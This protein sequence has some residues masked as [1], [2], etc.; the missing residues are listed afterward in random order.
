[1]PFLIAMPPELALEVV[2][3]VLRPDARDEIH[4]LDHHAV[5]GMDVGIAEQ[6][7]IGDEAAGPDAEHE[8]ALAHVVELG[9]LGGDDRRMVVGQVDDRG[10]ERDVL[11]A[12][13]EAG[14][15]HQRR[16]NGLGGGG[17]MLAQPEFIEAEPVGEHRLLAVLLERAPER[18]VWRMDRH[19]EHPQ[20]HDFLP[21]VRVSVLWRGFGRSEMGWFDLRTLTARIRG[22]QRAPQ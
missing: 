13:Q 6:L 20:A 14:E 1:M 17:E 22:L 2:R 16:G 21:T 3:R 18:A 7:E 10:A 4:R 5:A 19:H 9:G 11:G 15:E 12:L 8:A